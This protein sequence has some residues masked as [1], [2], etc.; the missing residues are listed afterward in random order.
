MEWSGEEG[1]KGVEEREEN[2]KSCCALLIMSRGG[3]ILARNRIYMASF[4]EILTP[5]LVPYM[6]IM[7]GKSGLDVFGP[8]PVRFARMGSHRDASRCEIRIRVFLKEGH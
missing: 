7:N 3:C 6:T 2:A 1:K 4:C 5:L 8:N